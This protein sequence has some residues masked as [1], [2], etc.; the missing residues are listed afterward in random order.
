MAEVEL[1]LRDGD[2]ALCSGRYRGALEAF[3][4]ARARI[5]QVLHPPFDADSYLQRMA[6]ALPVSAEIEKGLLAAS[7]RIAAL[8]RP[9]VAPTRPFSSPESDAAVPDAVRPY[10]QTGFREGTAGVEAAQVAGAQAI[11]LLQD[12]KA[13]P[14]FRLLREAREAVRLEGDADAALLATLEQNLAAAS[15]QIGGPDRAAEAARS[16][17]EQFRRAKD[18]V[19]EAQ[20]LHIAA[21]AAQQLGNRQE[22]E[23]LFNRAAELAARLAIPPVPDGRARPDPSGG[24]LAVTLEAGTLSAAAAG[25]LRALSHQGANT[26][27]RDPEALAAIRNRDASMI[28]LRLAGRVD[29]WASV[30]VQSAAQQR[31][32]ARPFQVGVQAGEQLVTFALSGSLPPS[33]LTVRLYEPRLSAQRAADLAWQ[34]GSTATL[35]LYLA[36]LYG[37]TLPV[38]IGDAYHALGLYSRAEEHYRQAAGYSFLNPSVEAT[39]LWIRLARNA[40]AWGSTLYRA[41]NL[42]AAG[43]QYVKIIGAAGEV[44]ASLLYTTASLSQPADAAR[45]LINGIV[46]RPLPEVNWEIAGLVLEANGYLQQ[47]AQGLDFYG[48]L[49][50]PIHTFEYLQGVARGFAREAIDAERQFI[51]FKERQEAEEGGRRDLEMAQAL[52]RAEADARF[53]QL[54]AARADEASARAALAL[55]ERRRDD[56]Q[57]QRNDYEQT[58]AT[59]IWAR[60]AAQALAGGQDA[61]YAEI[62]ELANRLDRGER[63]EGPGPKL[64]AAATLRAGRK[65]RAYELKR[66]D[67]NIEE[68]KKG[69]DLART[70]VTA[71]EHRTKAAELAWQAALQRGGLAEAALRAFDDEY[72]TPET[73]SKMADVLRDISRSYLDRGIRIAKLMERAYNFENDTEIRIIKTDYGHTVAQNAAGQEGRLLGGDSL[74]RDIDSFTYHAI[75]NKTRKESR[76]KDV[77]SLAGDFPAQFE[78]FRRTGLLVFETD[79]LEFDQRHP[80]FYAQ[81][82]EAVELE[83]VGL[84]PESGLNGTLAAGGVSTYRKRDGGTGR[85]VHAVDTMALSE[86]VLRHDAFLYGADT[87]VRG[88][89]QGLGAGTTWQIHLP[90]RSNPF[91]FRRIFD[92]RLALYYTAT[93]DGGLR[94]LV[95]ARPP[96]DGE[97]ERLK[98]FALRYDFPDAWYAFYR[99]GTARFTLDAYRLPPNQQAFQVLTASFRVV[100]KPGVPNAGIELRVTGPNGTTGTVTTDAQ[101]VVSSEDGALA[102]LGGANPLGAWEVAV[103]G[104]APLTEEGRVRFDRVYNLQFGLEYGF[105]FV[106]EVV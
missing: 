86:F 51:Q 95:L 99:D 20:A 40:L 93:H 77:I 38:R 8:V 89:F 62:S 44:P 61:L 5:Y 63:L 76:L 97:L 34:V 7:G 101:G 43:V 81:R 72:F 80:G 19:G 10:M 21:V 60:A 79:L 78:E 28:T 54:E 102:G 6:F 83:V 103:V 37:Y 66:M 29:G 53:Q 91:D 14:A 70:Q 96:R 49:L 35:T 106:G 39:A 92:L 90:R 100:T 58:S 65:T 104:G 3:Q 42:A 46:Q 24:A 82:I 2:A 105:Q 15:L 67:D 12:G 87:G 16:A 75:T 11:S 74:L 71:A 68:L 9:E 59:E 73:W 4:R 45:A 36:Q 47:I 50:S 69:V 84:L 48:L 52:A 64:A 31:E 32:Q 88:L 85:R 23:E 94:S 98:A 55:A 17:A 57:R 25:P 1:L 27:A 13:E 33:E 22:A 30:P 41:E 18:R 56:A 26:V